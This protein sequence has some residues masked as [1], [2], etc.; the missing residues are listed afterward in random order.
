MR[1]P[2]F[3]I[4]NE[5]LASISAYRTHD[6]PRIKLDANESPWPL[7]PE[8]RARIA[9]ALA[10]APLHRYPD[11]LAREV[12]ALIAKRIGASP[13]ELVLGAGSDEVIGILMAALNRGDRP[14]VVTPAP[15]FVMIPI[16]ARVHG[17]T[18]IEVPLAGDWSIDLGAMRRAIDEHRPNLVY[19]ATPNNPTGNRTL[20]DDL[21]S[22]RSDGLLVVDEAYGPFA[23]ERS[24]LFE[25]DVAHLGTLSKIGLAGLRL[26]WA[27]LDAALAREVEKARP[28]YNLSTYTQIAARVVL[29][30]MPELLDAQ[31]RAIVSERERLGAA[32]AALPVRVFPSEAN[33]FLVELDDASAVH[34]ALLAREIA[35]RRFADPRLAHHLRISVGTPEENDALLSALRHTL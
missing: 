22:L 2:P 17:L 10:D 15:S 4:V 23:S 16:T 18:P 7:P 31:V 26:G 25:P 8:A 30:E 12:R 29:G 24:Q 5:G 13:D 27:R 11:L 33:F 34:A 3:A 32:L 1:R 14:T 21:R 6:A 20:D 28:P 9:A 35:V 19:V